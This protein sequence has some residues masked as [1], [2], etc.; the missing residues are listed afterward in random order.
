[1]TP[2]ALT[3]LANALT[4][5][6]GSLMGVLFVLGLVV[7]G[8]IRLPR[9]I[10]SV[11]QQLVQAEARVLYEREIAE[12]WQTIALE[13]VGLTDRVVHVARAAVTG[14]RP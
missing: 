5:P 9:E 13:Q 12:R 11:Q 14:N 3:A 4:G 8:D 6:F 1:M 10:V 7:R 2:D